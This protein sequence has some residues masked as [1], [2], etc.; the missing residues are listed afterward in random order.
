[1]TSSAAPADGL[2]V[3]LAAEQATGTDVVALVAA[4]AVWANPSVHSELLKKRSLGLWYPGLRRYRKGA[5]EKKGQVVEGVRLDD[6]TYANSALKNA[7]PHGPR[8][9]VNYSV[10][11]I[12]NDSCYDE[13]CYTAIANLVLIPSPLMSLTDFHPELQEALR[14]RSWELY[15]WRPPGTVIP[16]KPTRYPAC[17]RLPEPYTAEVAARL[18]RL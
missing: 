1:M 9:Y 11:H 10:C 4:A 7:L 3:L 13:R 5:G 17:W 2:V 6:N 15:Q 16:S 14:Y 18:R 12:W 8:S